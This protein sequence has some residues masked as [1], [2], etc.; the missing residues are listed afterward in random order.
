[1]NE[2][3]LAMR[4]YIIKVWTRRNKLEPKE[5]EGFNDISALAEPVA[6]AIASDNAASACHAA[7]EEVLRHGCLVN[8]TEVMD[9]C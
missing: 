7:V 8:S 4:T 1:L 6:L 5:G 3:G 9:V 2:E